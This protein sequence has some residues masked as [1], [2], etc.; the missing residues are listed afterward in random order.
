V[1]TTDHS[2]GP[3]N[4]AS[5][6]RDAA[7]NADRTADRSSEPSSYDLGKL[8]DRLR[9]VRNR[10]RWTRGDVERLSDGRWTATAL[11]TYERAERALTA[12][13]L[14]L[15]ADF[16]R[17]SV[18]ELI[19]GSPPEP[20]ASSIET[21]AVIDTE[22]LFASAEWPLLTQFVLGVQ[23]ARSGGSRRLLRLRSRDLPRL[24]ALH[25]ETLERLLADL[26]QDK[27]LVA[28]LPMP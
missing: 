24:A 28:R 16:Y 5:G 20:R 12:V 13:N 19:D 21:V 14:M 10:R 27:I 7:R 23:Q 15:L 2:A 3:A 22:R 17:V 25:S 8:G 11:G 1:I 18:V 9:A 4:R 6:S 26:A